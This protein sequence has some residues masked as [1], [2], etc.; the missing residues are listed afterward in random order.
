MADPTPFRRPIN[1]NRL[2]AG[3]AE[4][5]IRERAKASSNVI[6]HENAHAALRARERDIPEPEVR[7]ILL[8]GTVIKSPLR[9]EH[10]DWE[11]IIQRRIKGARDAGVV[12]IIVRRDETLI[13]KTI[14]WMDYR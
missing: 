2:R 4:R 13:V 8:T 7:R 3:E 10:G 11:A 9:N 6:I 5:V 1:W 12:T 14:M